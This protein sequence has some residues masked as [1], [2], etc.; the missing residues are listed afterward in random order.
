MSEFIWIMSTKLNCSSKQILLNLGWGAFM[1]RISLIICFILWSQHLFYSVFHIILRTL[2][3]LNN[4]DLLYF[5][6]CWIPK[7][8][9]SHYI[10]FV[11]QRDGHRRACVHSSATT[12]IY[13]FLNKIIVSGWPKSNVYFVYTEN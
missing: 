13:V 5:I 2:F 11:Q 4:V 6:I 8:P 12:F 3:P 7:P 10:L 1:Q 9:K